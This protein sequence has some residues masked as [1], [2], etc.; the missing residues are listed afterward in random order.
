MTGTR[1]LPAIG[2]FDP[3]AST[4]HSLQGQRIEK[5]FESLIDLRTVLALHLKTPV[6]ATSG[7]QRSFSSFALGAYQFCDTD[8]EVVVHDQNFAASNDAIVDIN[9]NGVAGERVEGDDAAIAKLKYIL[10]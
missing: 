4:S 2:D 8:A 10:Q 6:K 3:V 9:G 5:R 7:L 1:S